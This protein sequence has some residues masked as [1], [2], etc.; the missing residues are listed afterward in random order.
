MIPVMEPQDPLERIHISRGEL[1]ALLIQSVM[2]AAAMTFSVAIVFQRH[3]G[4][5]RAIASGTG[6]LVGLL[7]SYPTIRMLGRAD[8]INFSFYKWFAISLAAAALATLVIGV[9]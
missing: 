1:A 6:L 9:F 3:A 8:G 5:S 4:M 7:C 2:L